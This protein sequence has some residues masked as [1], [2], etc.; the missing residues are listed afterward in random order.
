[1]TER[2]LA[3]C[4]KL[5]DKAGKLDRR[6]LCREL[7]ADDPR[8]RDIVTGLIGSL[9][10]AGRFPYTFT[11]P[12]VGAKLGVKAATKSGKKAVTKS[13]GKAEAS[14]AQ[15]APSEQGPV[16]FAPPPQVDYARLARLAAD[17]VWIFEAMSPEERV[18][19]LALV[20][21]RFA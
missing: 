4:K 15:V 17:V 13:G 1:M 12:K 19:A 11:D 8:S 16:P 2:I 3:T 14:V 21:N 7:G 20:Q 6:T 10:R 5:A 9:R 18:F